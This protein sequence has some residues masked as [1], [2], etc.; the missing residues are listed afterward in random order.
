MLSDKITG[1]C[2]FLSSDILPR[3]KGV[4]LL[5]G[6]WI[7][8]LDLL[9]LYTQLIITSNTALPPVSA[10]VH[11]CKDYSSQ[12][13]FT[14][15]FLLTNV[16]SGDYT[17]LTV[18]AADMKSF[19]HS[20]TFNSAALRSIFLMPQFIHSVLSLGSSAPRFTFWQAGVPK[21]NSLSP[22]DLSRPWILVIW[23]RGGSNRKHRF[24]TSHLFS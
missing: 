19:L 5:G 16:N 14:S 12:F 13:D 11:C 23:P 6:V 17:S 4:W 1:R 10:L 8:C 24:L 20:Q 9:Q 3:I 15:R 7:G 2:W 21:L 22:S 18:T